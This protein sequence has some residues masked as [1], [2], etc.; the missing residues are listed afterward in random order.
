VVYYLLQ[1][2]RRG[3]A[4]LRG[5]GFFRWVKDR[6]VGREGG[7]DQAPAGFLSVESRKNNLL[8]L[9][10]GM[11]TRNDFNRMG[12]EKERN[13]VPVESTSCLQAVRGE[14]TRRLN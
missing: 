5:R 12:G 4:A 9:K 8:L 1:E 6:I 7:E 10:I 13:F 3:E 14:R 11:E 2:R